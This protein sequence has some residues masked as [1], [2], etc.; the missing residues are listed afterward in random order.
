MVTNLD[1]DNLVIR[2]SIDIGDALFSSF[3][4]SINETMADSKNISMRGSGNDELIF[5]YDGIRINIFSL[6]KVDLEY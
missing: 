6:G 2:S 5:L 3:P 4:I 1:L